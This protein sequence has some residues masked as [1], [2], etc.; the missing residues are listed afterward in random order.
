MDNERGTSEL[1][2]MSEDFNL[3][4]YYNLTIITTK[5]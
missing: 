1:S 5:K 3:I 2:M 4:Y